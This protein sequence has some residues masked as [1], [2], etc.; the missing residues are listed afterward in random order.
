LERKRSPTINDVAARAGVSIATES[1]ALNG[2]GQVRAETRARVL[3]V[4]GALAYYLQ[5]EDHC[6]K[7]AES[8]CRCRVPQV[9]TRMN[10]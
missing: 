5:R 4:A 1:K 6:S 10:G 9:P 8:T 3:R 7:A 2:R